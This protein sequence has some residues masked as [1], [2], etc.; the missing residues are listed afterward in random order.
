M[1]MLTDFDAGRLERGA[2]YRHVKDV[3][4][5]GSLFHFPDDVRQLRP[6]QPPRCYSCRRIFWRSKFFF[7]L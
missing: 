4:M 3:A 1:L 6:V 2:V 7:Q 5:G